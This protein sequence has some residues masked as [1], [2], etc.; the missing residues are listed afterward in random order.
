MGILVNA[1]APTAEI[2]GRSR[3][4]CLWMDACRREYGDLLMLQCN[5]V[6]GM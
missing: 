5:H 4:F 2:E 3:Q 6:L 1:Y